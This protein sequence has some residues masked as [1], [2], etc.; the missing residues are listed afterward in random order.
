MRKRMFIQWQKRD[1]RLKRID[2]KS[3]EVQDIWDLIISHQADGGWWSIDL[4]RGMKE[5]ELSKIA[6]ALQNRTWFAGYDVDILVVVPTIADGICF[7]W[8]YQKEIGWHEEVLN[9]AVQRKMERAQRRK[10][11]GWK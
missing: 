3:V 2:C 11:H 1:V 7:R 10:E 5:K 8:K 6:G 4:T 9:K